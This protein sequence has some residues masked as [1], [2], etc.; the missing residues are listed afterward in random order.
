MGGYCV[1]KHTSPSGK[2]YIGIT[3]NNPTKRWRNGKG[4][5]ENSYFWR[6][7]CKY[8]WD[9]FTHEIV[10]SLLSREEAAAMEVDLIAKYKSND[11]KHG[12][13]ITAGGEVNILP[14]SSLDKISEKNK[15]M[16][17]TEEHRKK[18]SEA[19]KKLL[20]EHPEKRPSRKGCKL[21]EHQMRLLI[22]ASRKAVSKKVECV[23]TGAVY[24]SMTEASRATG[25]NLSS[26]SETLHGKQKRAAGFT[27]RY[28]EVVE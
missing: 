20:A 11:P 26:L 4:Y 5:H 6:A 12:Y 17:F 14:R 24:S 3:K 18:I 21:S 28:V 19:R 27:W 9:S 7:I 23:E 8:G 2:V 10:A 25:V 1:Y 15:H 16:V 13:N 22:E